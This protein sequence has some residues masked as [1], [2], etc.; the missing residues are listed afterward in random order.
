[1]TRAR[2]SQPPAV[3]EKFGRWT[4]TGEPIWFPVAGQHRMHV[5]VKCECGTEQVILVQSLRRKDR[6]NPSCGC[7]KREQAAEQARR[8]WTKHGMAIH[9]EQGQDELYRLW[10]LMNRRCYNPS[11]DNYKYYGGRGIGVYE[12]WRTDAGV[13]ITWI[14]ENLGRRPGGKT[15]GGAWKYTLDRI[16]NNGNYEPGNLKWSDQFEQVKN[17]RN[18]RG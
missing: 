5:P 10:K 1:M 13:F 2:N 14:E 12:P 11:A 4:V 6:A 7:W 15:T 16:D 17:S 18:Y 8:Q 9:G 3:G